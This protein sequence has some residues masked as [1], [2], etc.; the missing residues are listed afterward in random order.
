MARAG[1][2]VGRS[3]CE[4]LEGVWATTGDDEAGVSRKKPKMAT[5]SG[6]EGQLAERLRKYGVEKDETVLV[7]GSSV[8]GEWSTEE[9]VVEKEARMG[10]MRRGLKRAGVDATTRDSRTP[11]CAQV[12]SSEEQGL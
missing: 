8:A 5:S 6:R 4:Q 1:E 12:A 11:S 3:V 9:V 10:G 2:L 7:A